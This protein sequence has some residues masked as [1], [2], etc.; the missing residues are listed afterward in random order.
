MPD[1]PT[2][3]QTG[4]VEE[5]T[6]QTV[7]MASN[8]LGGHPVDCSNALRKAATPRDHTIAAAEPKYRGFGA[9]ICYGVRC[10]PYMDSANAQDAPFYDDRTATHAL[11]AQH[12]NRS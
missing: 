11:V 4:P 12:A 3:R 5:R 7:D 8:L 9:R 10:D 2:S 6:L 1:L